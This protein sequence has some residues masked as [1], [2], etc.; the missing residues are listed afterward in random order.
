MINK[1]KQYKTILNNKHN[2]EIGTN[3]LENRYRN[4][5]NENKKNIKNTVYSNV[6]NVI[7][8]NINKSHKR[9]N[10]S[11]K[12]SNINKSKLFLNNSN[13]NF[14][15]I[16]YVNIDNGNNDINQN[17]NKK[18]INYT[19]N[20]NSKNKKNING[21][22][23]EKDFQIM[24][25][26][27]Q[28]LSNTININGSLN[29]FSINESKASSKILFDIPFNSDEL[30]EKKEKREK[31]LSVTEM[32][33]EK[34]NE[35]INKLNNDIDKYDIYNN[36]IKE[37]LE[38][39]NEEKLINKIQISNLSLKEF[40]ENENEDYND[41][42]TNNK[43]ITGS[44]MN[45]NSN[46]DK[47]IH[48][49]NGLENYN[50]NIDGNSIIDNLNIIDKESINYGQKNEKNYEIDILEENNIDEKEEENEYDIGREEKF[51]KPL[52]KY[53]NKFNLEQINPF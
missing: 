33:Y 23:T 34:L 32:K 22:L 31:R 7:N 13:K 47:N 11:N 43:N 38:N 24:S 2:I 19:N 26:E 16:N 9:G 49:Q 41:E 1:E 30:E 12:L 18:E 53:E 50:I 45:I 20:K 35:F 17:I 6:I 52:T 46:I 51:Y 14:N 36:D 21:L 8:N 10:N 15:T 39:K 48:I 42:N 44:I 40:E 27:S 37:E 28:L 29:S 25:D 5:I 4:N 3:G